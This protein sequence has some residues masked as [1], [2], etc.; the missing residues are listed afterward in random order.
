V[1]LHVPSF[2]KAGVDRNGGSALRPLIRTCIATGL[3]KLDRSD[4]A[5][6][7]AQR[8]WGT[9]RSVDFVMRAASSPTSLANTPGSA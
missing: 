1:I 9:D 7:Y 2:E 4:R 3:A 6:E 5:P 8:R